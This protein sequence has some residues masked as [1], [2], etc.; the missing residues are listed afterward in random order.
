M[1]DV[2]QAGTTWMAELVALGA[3][4][5]STI[6]FPAGRDRRLVSRH[7]SPPTASTATPGRPLVRRHP[8]AVLSRR[9]PRAARLRDAAERLGRL[10][11][12]HASDL[13]RAGRPRSLR[14]PAAAR[15][16]ADAGHP[17]PPA[18]RPPASRRGRMG[19]LPDRRHFAM[20]SSST[21]TSSAGSRPGRGQGQVANLYQD[22][23]AGFFSVFITGP[24]NLGELP[25][26][27]AGLQASWAT[28]PMPAPA[29]VS[30]GLSIAGGAS[31]AIAADTPHA[32]A[33]WA[34]VSFLAAAEHQL[35]FYRLSGDLPAR[36]RR[37]PRD[38]SPTSPA[39]PPSGPSSST[40]SRPRAS[41]NGS[42]S[43][44]PSAAP[45]SPP[46]AATARPDEA[47]PSSI[48][49]STPSSPSAAGC[50]SSG[51]LS[52]A[53]R[54]WRCGRAAPRS[55]GSSSARM[56]S[57]PG[58]RARSRT[59]GARHQ[60]R[61]PEPYRRRQARGNRSRGAGAA[62]DRRLLL[63]PGRGVAA[64]QPHRL[65]H[66]RHRQP[67]EPARRRPR[68]LPGA[69]A[70]P[71]VLAALLNTAVFVV[72][73]APLSIAVSLAAA[74]LVTAAAVRLAACSARSSS[75]RW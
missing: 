31:L 51:A 75:S 61:T 14:P 37:G 48:A 46:C 49:R 63:P 24:W 33:A 50:W 65:R 2:F 56:S 60:R 41:P 19:R 15:R 18:R 72:V 47:L 13:K 73:A 9:P 17:R 66:L 53:T 8:S 74:L 59:S 20:P 67:R 62:A 52:S 42:A 25:P 43:P 1:P 68:Q 10:A 6:I 69:G 5:R 40:S 38:G 28:A 16:V 4:R 36:P 45:P 11:R 23:A 12:R 54:R 30:A 29:P 55:G 71:A 34:L 3:V 21:S 35:A 58:A 39:S 27:A 57:Q 26:Y 7:R 44:P 64:A 70:R 22:F 32:E